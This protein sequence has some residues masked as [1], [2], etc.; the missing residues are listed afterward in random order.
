MKFKRQKIF[1]LASSALHQLDHI[2]LQREQRFTRYHCLKYCYTCCQ[3]SIKSL[4]KYASK[5]AISS[6]RES[7]SNKYDHKVARSQATFYV[8]SPHPKLL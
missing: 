2:S 3:V 4:T 5:T 6:L 7:Y 8:C 1:F